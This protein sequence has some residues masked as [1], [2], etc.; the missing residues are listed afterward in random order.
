MKEKSKRIPEFVYYSVNVSNKLTGRNGELLNKVYAADSTKED[1]IEH[2]NYRA[3]GYGYQNQQ[4]KSIVIPIENTGITN[5]RLLTKSIHK[6]S[7]IFYN[8]YDEDGFVFDV[9]ADEILEAST[10]Q[11]IEPGG[12]LLG[13]WFWVNDNGL[14]LVSESSE[15]YHVIK[16]KEEMDN[17]PKLKK[18]EIVPGFFYKGFTK[19]V[20]YIRDFNPMKV[21]C[22]MEQKIIDHWSRKERW[23]RVSWLYNHASYANDSMFRNKVIKI[24][25]NNTSPSTKL[26][27]KYHIVNDDN[28]NNLFI[29]EPIN[30]EMLNEIND[31]CNSSTMLEL[32]KIPYYIEILGLEKT[33]EKISSFGIA[34]EVIE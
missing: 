31:M 26:L 29:K 10:S 4:T 33:V 19:Q 28:F 34:V 11:G 7:A 5:L 21:T 17:L 14:K 18:K 23:E 3:M 6:P 12:K 22:D 25:K 27:F 15:T 1:K 16:N 30:N 2:A 20:F 8:V 24:Y 9:N 32:S 13:K